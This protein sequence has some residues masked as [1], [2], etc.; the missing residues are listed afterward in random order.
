MQII[1]FFLSDFKKHLNF[2]EGFSK[3][4]MLKHQIPQNSP[5]GSRFV[6][7]GDGQVERQ[8]KANSPFSEFCEQT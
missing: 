3:K 5:D 7:C 8:G 6:P 1:T 4:K 2:F